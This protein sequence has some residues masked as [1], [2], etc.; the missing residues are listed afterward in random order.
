[1][2]VG[3]A[4]ELS[5]QQARAL[6]ETARRLQVSEAE[7]ATAAVRDLV[8]RRSIDFPAAADRVLNR[9]HELYRRLS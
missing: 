2:P 5:D 4:I 9:N 8:A 7:L 1:V 3:I 6:S